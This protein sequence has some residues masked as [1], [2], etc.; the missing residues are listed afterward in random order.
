MAEANGTPSFPD[1]DRSELDR[2]IGE[3]IVNAQK[4]LE[5]QGR[6]RNLLTASQAVVEELELGAVLRRI[7][8]A[9]VDLVGAKYGALGVIAPD[10]HL[11]QFIHVGIDEELAARI[12]ELPHGRGVLGALIEDPH[13]I[14][15]EHL[16]SDPRSAGFPPNHPPMDSFLGVPVRVR[17]VVFGN[18]YL[19]E[20]RSG[21]F[22]REDEELLTALAAT[23][24]IAI[25]NARLFD[26][27]RRRQ[28]WSSALAEVTA[29]LLSEP[30]GD[31]LA[32][33]TERVAALAE[34]DLAVIAR[35][36]GDG[37]FVVEHASGELGALA[38]GAVFPA[39]GSLAGRALDAGQPVLVAQTTAPFDPAVVLGSTMAIPVLLAGDTRAAI[40]VARAT[41]RPGFGPTDIEMTADFVGQTSVAVELARVRADQ[42]RFV[43]LEDRSRIARDLHDHV[44]QRLFA[45]GLGL[46]S[47]VG[48]I[49]DPTARARVS[50]EVDSLDDAIRQIRT[51]IF[52]LTTQT[53][54]RPPVRHRV[55]DVLSELGPLFESSPR[56]AFT[57]P[58]DTRVPE[59]VAEDLLA[60]VREA[61]SNVARHA[62]AT[63]TSVRLAVRLDEL[64]LEVV[65]DGVGIPEG[66]RRSGLANIE[67]RASRWN[68]EAS[69]TPRDGGGTVLRWR[70]ELPPEPADGP[71]ETADGAA[72][73]DQ[74]I[75]T[76]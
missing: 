29:T 18:L 65:D 71:S 30:S 41:G 1:S 74:R 46:Q 31:P 40:V 8:A 64:E 43:L 6:L 35:P 26:E 51:A 61:L 4:V 75:E 62:H 44:I 20:Q 52:A 2:A 42:E 53:E 56:L 39:S 23:A 10:G 57:G 9:A 72:T 27:T 67:E 49:A 19:S 55:I 58:V 48:R 16:G 12:G 70:V 68:G 73:T 28:R 60:V 14:R 7:V 38:A 13:A 54:K 59:E 11:E 32:L 66:G 3:L 76:P 33:V 36:A 5:T 63:E 69:T 17:D 47:V 22:S 45:A 25:D 50:T 24:G 21:H 34:A 15:L 37:V